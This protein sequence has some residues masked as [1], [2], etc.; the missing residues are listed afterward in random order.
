M[1]LIT[2]DNATFRVGRNTILPE[3][4]WEIKEGEHWAVVGPNGS[5]KSTLV[6]ALWGGTAL[7]RGKIMW[8]FI[9][10]PQEML[11]EKLRKKI[12]Y[13]S[14]ELEQQMVKQERQLA[15]FREYRGA[16]H[17]FTTAAFVI[18]GSYKKRNEV[19]R[20]LKIKHLIDKDITTL[21]TGESRKVLLARALV[22]KPKVLILDEP[23][24]GLDVE[25]RKNFQEILTKIINQNDISI[26]LVTHRKEEIIS[27]IKNIFS[28]G[29]S[30]KEQIVF[31]NKLTKKTVNFSDRKEIVR[32]E[33]VSISYGNKK[34]LNDFSWTIKEGEKWALL[35]SNGSGKSTIIKLI[36]GDHPHAY[37][38]DIWLFGKKR[39]TGESIWEIKRQIGLVS[40]DIQLNYL[41]NLT[42]L[43]V[44][45]SG[46][47]DSFGLYNKPNKLQLAKIHKLADDMG[48]C[49][50]L[51]KNYLDCSNGQK[52]MLILARAL[53]KEPKMLILDEPC[54]GLDISN[55]NKILQVIDQ[56]CIS[57]TTIILV[58]HHQDEISSNIGLVK[59][60]T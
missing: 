57:S 44:I 23:F 31:R 38:N 20:L 27:Q 2:I 1:K 13:V 6:K 9:R 34:V 28:L 18:G 53:I 24:D 39:G 33:K 22:K 49:Q 51:N 25:S 26:I 21:S 48:I 11:Y 47:F 8:H 4:S 19:C 10:K 29:K 5:G 7:S 12:G 56:L 55:R 14:F 15:E 58:T 42:G 3:T 46:F 45:A 37:A 30:K 35:G 59:R 40:S 54:N 50:L 60:L 36:T 16:I 32:M 41:K 52:R 17:E 43:D